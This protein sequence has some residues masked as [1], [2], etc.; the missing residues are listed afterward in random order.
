MASVGL[1]VVPNAW[2][3]PLLLGVKGT[4]PDPGSYRF[5]TPAE[6]LE[7]EGDTYEE[8]GGLPSMYQKAHE[9]REKSVQDWQKTVKD[10]HLNKE[11]W[12]QFQALVEQK[13]HDWLLES[14]HR[15]G[16]DSLIPP[17]I[18]FQDASHSDSLEAGPNDTRQ[19]GTS[20][21]TVGRT[22]FALL[23]FWVLVDGDPHTKKLLPHSQLFASQPLVALSPLFACC[24]QFQAGLDLI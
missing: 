20:R 7:L 8:P 15:H 11:R 2:D 16:L 22:P 9:E 14:G 18:P 17:C 23:T 5:L 10:A 21:W 4:T 13:F 19:E 6:F 24:P 1:A 12:R 3:Q